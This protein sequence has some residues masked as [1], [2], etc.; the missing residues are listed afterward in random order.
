MPADFVQQLCTKPLVN[1]QAIVN[2]I[3]KDNNLVSVSDKQDDEKMVGVIKH[4]VKMQ[5]QLSAFSS[6]QVKMATML[7]EMKLDIIKAV[8]GTMSE[9][10]SQLINM[11]ASSTEAI[12]GYFSQLRDQIEESKQEVITVIREESAKSEKAVTDL[13]NEI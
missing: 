4:M 7:P 13:K 11:F 3:V 10:M 9:E 1:F 5:T 8:G 12:E 2:K 6:S